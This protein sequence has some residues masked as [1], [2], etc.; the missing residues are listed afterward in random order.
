MFRFT[1][2]KLKDFGGHA[3]VIKKSMGSSLGLVGPNGSGKST[4]LQA[5]QLA[6]EGSVNHEDALAEFIRTDSTGNA[7][8]KFVTEHGFISNGRRGRIK[9]EVL[10]SGGVKRELTMEGLERKLTGAGDV[11]KALRDIVG[12]DSKAIRSTV[13][14]PQGSLDKLFAGLDSERRDFYVRL[15]ALGHLEKVADVVEGFRK[16]VSG[17]LNDLTAVRDGAD[18]ALR[19]ASEYFENLYQEL[20]RMTAFKRE[21]EFAVTLQNLM[22]GQDE[23]NEKKTQASGALQQVLLSEGVSAEGA[24]KWVAATESRVE[25]LKLLTAEAK[26]NWEHRVALDTRK[27]TADATVAKMEQW[28][29]WQSEVEA[30]KIEVDKVAEILRRPDP[31]MQITRLERWATAR[32]ER[33]MTDA[34]VQVARGKLPE[35][36]R[37]ADETR[38]AYEAARD[39]HQ[40]T[41][42][43]WR[44]TRDLVQKQKQ[45]K[46]EVDELVECNTS[47]C[48]AMCGSKTPD[49]TYL[50]T[51]IA[52][53]ERRMAADQVEGAAQAAAMLEAEKA[54]V[55]PKKELDDMLA[56]VRSWTTKLEELDRE[57]AGAPPEAE[58]ATLKAEAE[59]QVSEY[60]EASAING[61]LAREIGELEA[62]QRGYTC[63]ATDLADWRVEVTQVAAALEHQRG[64]AEALRRNHTQLNEELESLREKLSRVAGAVTTQKNRAEAAVDAALAVGAK[65]EELAS[66]P[67][68]R[69]KLQAIGD[70]VT[71]E[72]LATVLSE[73]RLAETAYNEQV[74]K[75]EAARKSM[76]DADGRLAEIDLRVA[77][78]KNRI[79]LVEELSRLAGAFKPSGVTMDF[80]DYQFGQI[81]SLTQEHLSEMGAD[82]MVAAS[83]SKPLA[84]EFLRLNRPNEAWLRQSR[85]SGGQKVRLALAVLLAIH[86]LVLPD[87]GLLVLD[88]PSLHLD[89]DAKLT[90]GEVIRD[91]CEAG[92]EEGRQ[93]II[94]D[95]DQRLMSSLPDV[96]EFGQL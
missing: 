35:L 23:A 12:A 53:G 2:F 3:E 76:A 30:K 33:T 47:P 68:L 20:R 90:F 84:F 58:W 24:P 18:D 19:Q 6:L 31:R 64:D 62:K 9:R 15:L 1:D 8:I 43:L 75:V 89:E 70:V 74:G 61:R 87:V 88:E 60:A 56:N 63:T 51:Q 54:A 85:M 22:T 78:Q 82:F 49:L 50:D 4:I 16:Q 25:E 86:E 38:S 69:A 36:Q 93:I 55:E 59:G 34:R 94:C 32:T 14:I 67:V 29:G 48:C 57:L 5:F 21:I 72:A 39:A 83:E 42:R 41:Q 27:T 52:E 79:T 92:G 40:L 71:S 17:S 13:F 96:M 45:L 46:K 65:V 26:A 7:P 44:E 73:L 28:L 66:V 95:H 80:L 37:A 10:R 77:E 11:E 81:A 91:L